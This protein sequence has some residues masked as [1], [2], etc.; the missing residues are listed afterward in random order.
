MKRRDNSKGRRGEE[1]RVVVAKVEFNGVKTPNRL[2][3]AA[4]L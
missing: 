4:Y 3:D 1:K 2:S